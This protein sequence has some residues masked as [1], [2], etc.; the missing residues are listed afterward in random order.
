VEAGVDRGEMIAQREVPILPND[1]AATL[2]Q[3]IQVT[4]RELL[5]AVI[6]A[7]AARKTQPRSDF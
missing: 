5:P 1:T 4:E 7:L 2:H 3:R 6:N